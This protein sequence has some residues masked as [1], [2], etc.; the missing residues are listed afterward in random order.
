MDSRNED[1]DFN[2]W[3]HLVEMFGGDSPLLIVLNEKYQRGLM[4]SFSHL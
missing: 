2:Y 4:K 3:L 1:T